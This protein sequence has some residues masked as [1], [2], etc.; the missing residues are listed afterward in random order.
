MESYA[1][2]ITRL[3]DEKP[4]MEPFC[5]GDIAIAVADAYHIPLARAKAIT[6]N[7][8]KRIADAGQIERVQKGLYYK[9]KQTVFGKVRLN[10]DQLAIQLLTK[11]D[12]DVIGYVSGAAFLNKIGLSTLLPKQI[13]VVTNQYRRVLPEGCHI[14]V[15]RP[16][17][18]ITTEN[19][20]YLQLLDAI[21]AMQT[22]H[23]DAENPYELIRAAA[24]KSKIHPLNLIFHARQHYPVQT[25]LRTVDIFSEG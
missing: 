17:T 12:Q 24:Q 13:D 22:S 2:F 10:Y 3:V 1:A 18:M 5:T 8:M 6:N 20:S 21:E 14:T 15:K 4:T 16:A 25:L 23:V 19:Y 11:Q 7:Q 9:P